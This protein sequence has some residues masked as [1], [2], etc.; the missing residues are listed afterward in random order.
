VDKR[1]GGNAFLNASYTLSRLY[2]NYSGL[3]STD[4]YSVNAGVGRDS[5][6]VNRFFDTPFGHAVVGGDA[7]LGRLPTDRPHVFKAF[8]AYTF[9]SADSFFRL[10]SNNEL[11]LSGFFTA[12][13][14]TP[15]T[16]RVDLVDDAYITLFGRGDLGRTKMFN[17]TDLQLTY[18]YRFGRDNRWGL[19]FNVDVLNAFNQATVLQPFES[20]ADHVFEPGDFALLGVN[21]GD[22]QDFDR[23]FFDGRI[24]AD[25]IMTLINTC[26]DT[27]P[28]NPADPTT[29]G[30]QCDSVTVDPRYGQPQVFQ[31]PRTVR[32]GFRFTF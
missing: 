17:Q 32:F 24:T 29:I 18:R 31:A 19:E 28:D 11:E 9:N 4:E 7:N 10:P 30:P 8:A 1:F 26:I 21:I 15:I 23:A 16:T 5:P 25:R 2:G 12:Q 14:G 27:V 22:T 3:A 13:S 6:N 20:I